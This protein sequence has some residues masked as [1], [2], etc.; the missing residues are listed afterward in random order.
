VASPS[1]A[2]GAFGA[3]WVAGVVASAGVLDDD[4]DRSAV[5]TTVTTTSSTTASAIR[6]RV[7][8]WSGRRRG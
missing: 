8:R 4:P 5:A 7:R 6:R 2:G 1:G 3:S